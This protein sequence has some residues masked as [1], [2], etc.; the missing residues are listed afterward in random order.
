MRIATRTTTT[1]TAT[2]PATMPRVSIWSGRIT[3]RNERAMRMH[4]SPKAEYT[5]GPFIMPGASP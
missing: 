2:T 4:A 1:R 3:I 5:N